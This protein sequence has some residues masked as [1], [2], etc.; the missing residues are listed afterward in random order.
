[1]LQIDPSE[2]LLFSTFGFYP[3]RVQHFN[4][5]S[6]ILP[7]TQGT[8]AVAIAAHTQHGGWIMHY[9]S[10][11]PDTIDSVRGTT[12]QELVRQIPR[13][14]IVRHLANPSSKL[15]RWPSMIPQED[16]EDAAPTC[17]VN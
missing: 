11:A 1:M 7:N 9:Y 2:L 4:D 14:P 8:H 3:T 13:L 17:L 6:W 10:A 5:V 12:L 15:S 16:P